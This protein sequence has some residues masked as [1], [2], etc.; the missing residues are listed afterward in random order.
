MLQGLVLVTYG[1]SPLPIDLNLML[2]LP[3]LKSIFP[4][5]KRKVNSLKDSVTSFAVNL[6]FEEQIPP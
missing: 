6:K 3:M 2:G 1:I 4:K 5:V